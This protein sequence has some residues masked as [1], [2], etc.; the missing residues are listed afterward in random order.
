MLGD[1]VGGEV[2]GLVAAAGVDAEPVGAGAGR[3]EVGEVFVEVGHEGGD[4]EG[5]GGGVEGDLRDLLPL[6]GVRRGRLAVGG[7]RDVD[8]AG[9]DA[10]V[11]GGVAGGDA[12]EPGV[13]GVRLVLGDGSAGVGD[14]E[15]VVVDADRALPGGEGIGHCGCPCR[16][17]VT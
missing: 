6:P 2:D 8:V 9:V 11:D 16:W 1:G 15:L 14:E 13:R 17:T 3:G 12:D 10:G 4:L 5:A 7:D